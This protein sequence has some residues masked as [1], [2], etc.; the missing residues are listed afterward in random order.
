[1]SVSDV[2]PPFIE[3][4]E[5]FI[6]QET[7]KTTHEVPYFIV[8]GSK[9]RPVLDQNGDSIPRPQ[10]R[11]IA[12]LHS[13]AN[14]NMAFHSIRISSESLNVLNHKLSSHL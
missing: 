5:F 6:Q 8:D 3:L 7:P 14:F 10:P 12:Q 1:M 4:D 11:Q 9:I 13:E 2:V